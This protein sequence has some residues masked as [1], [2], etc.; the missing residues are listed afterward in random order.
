MRY[1]VLAAILAVISGFLAVEAFRRTSLYG[2]L[3]LI[4]PSWIIY[5]V[6]AL[7]V[8]GF[9][10]ERKVFGSGYYAS[11]MILAL[12]PSI[13]ESEVFEGILDA[14][15]SLGYESISRM[16]LEMFPY[17]DSFSTAALITMLYILGIYSE[18]LDEYEKELRSHGYSFSLLPTLVFL[19]IVISAIYPNLNRIDVAG[20][21]RANFPHAVVALIAFSLSLITLWRMR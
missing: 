18:N 16:V 5:A 21:L 10:S 3:T 20:M 2:V 1:R 4:M 13:Q 7:P 15:Y 9:L 11:L 6:P 17:Q 8:L 19:V 14:L 12:I